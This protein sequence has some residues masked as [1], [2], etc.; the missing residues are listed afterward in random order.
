MINNTDFLV[1]IPHSPPML[2]IDHVEMV[3]SNASKAK[4]IIHKNSPFFLADKGVPAWIG[5]EYMGQTAALIAAYQLQEGN[6]E[7][8]IGLLLGTRKFVANT[9]WFLEGSNLLVSCNEI[10]VVGATLATFDC[11][12]HDVDNDIELA[13]ARLSVFRKPRN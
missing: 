12:I 7:P 11:S 1:L 3:S 13:S 5:V 9:A 10:A 8:H 2:L 4:T 6:V